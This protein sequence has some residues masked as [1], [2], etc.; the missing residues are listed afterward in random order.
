MQDELEKG[1]A[2]Y[3]KAAALNGGL[4]DVWTNL[5]LCLAKREEVDEAEECLLRALDLQS[6]STSALYGLGHI[7]EM[8]GRD[9]EA[10]NLFAQAMHFGF[11]RTTALF[12]LASIATRQGDAAGAIEYLNQLVALNQGDANIY[13]NLALA[14]QD[15]NDYEKAWESLERALELDPKHVEALSNSAAI[16]NAQGDFERAIVYSERSLAIDPE[17]AIAYNNLG[18]SYR[19]LI[20]LDDS[21]SAYRKAIQI[22]PEKAEYYNNLALVL[23]YAGKIDEMESAFKEALR[24]DPEYAIALTNYSS[25]LLKFGRLSE[26]KSLIDKALILNSASSIAWNNLARYH[27]EVGAFKE[28]YRAYKR[29]LVLD[30]SSALGWT[31]IAATQI[32]RDD[33]SDREVF[34]QHLESGRE[35]EKDIEPYEHLASDRSKSAGERLTIGFLSADFK[36]HSVAFFLEPLLEALDRG[37][38]SVICYSGVRSKDKVTQR[39]E[40]LADSWRDVCDTPDDQLAKQIREEQVDILIDMSGYTAGN[41]A[42]ALAY[43]PA[44]VQANWLGYAHSLGMGRFDFRIVDGVTDPEGVTLNSETLVRMP[45]TFLVYRPSAEAP[46]VKELP[47]RS[48]GYITFGC[49]NNLTKLSDKS[50][51]LFSQALHAVPNSK[52]M[53]KSYQA[54][55]RTVLRRLLKK[56]GQQGIEESRLELLPKFPKARDHLETYNRVDIALDT[57]PYNGTTTTCEALWMGVPVLTLL[58]TRHASRVSAT[59][60]GQLGLDSFIADSDARFAAKAA[61]LATDIEALASIRASLRERLERSPLRDEAGFAKDFAAALDSMWSAFQRKG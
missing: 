1:E 58:G 2:A 30:P 39:F 29:F 25:S 38:Y 10:R 17:C 54:T 40:A 20:R 5:G 7:R 11:D 12:R 48:N 14:F 21:I 28:S 51:E 45:K 41:R 44:P 57:F 8:Q 32:A 52:L 4:S 15:L 19:A 33:V 34:E 61:E 23:D 3:R 35:I 31:S 27:Y 55:D 36:T 37:A 49:F 9:D 24:L 53:L 42:R 26:A 6:D 13:N 22:E 60:L 59:F 47:V 46:D 43:K 50:V 56:F 18:A 16:L